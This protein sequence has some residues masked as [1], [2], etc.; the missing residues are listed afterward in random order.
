MK[1]KQKLG[2]LGVV[3]IIMRIDVHIQTKRLKNIKK[4]NGL[5]NNAIF[6]DRTFGA[7]IEDMIRRV[8]ITIKTYLW[9][10]ILIYK[11]IN[12]F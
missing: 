10:D 5:I 8:M 7:N 9:N 12:I 4:K 3:K 1:K 11:L 6:V 2:V